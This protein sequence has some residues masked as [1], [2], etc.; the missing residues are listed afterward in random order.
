MSV[1][2]PVTEDELCDFLL[3]YD[4][5]ALVNYAG[6]ESGIENTNYFVTT[7]KGEFVLTLF[8]QHTADELPFF[9]D[10]TAYLSEHAIPCAHP[11]QNRAGR[12]LEELKNKPAALVQRLRGQSVE[13]P[14]TVQCAAVGSVLARLHLAGGGFKQSR[15]NPRGP[16]W[17]TQTTELLYE[18]IDA[19]DQSI[20]E[21]ELAF[22][23]NHKNDH[24]NRGI[25]HAD[26]F[27]DNVLFVQD[28]LAGLIDFYYA[29]TDILLFDLAVTVNDWCSRPDGGIESLRYEQMLAAYQRVNPISEPDA[30]AWGAMLRAA[31]LR[32]WLSRL[33]DQH[34]PRSGEITHIKNPDDFKRILLDRRAREYSLPSVNI[35]PGAHIEHGSA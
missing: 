32:F 1:Y 7:D 6:I 19:D 4:V 16:D 14:N 27:R 21:S 23:D 10:L 30:S 31:A 29:C 3:H 20:L 25:I 34:F 22:Q 24:L 33:L 28:E 2:T 13:R 35:D 17:W 12:Y 9:L 5:G 15:E 26:L 8:E 11:V 18:K